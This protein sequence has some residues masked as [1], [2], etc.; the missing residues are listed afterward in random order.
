MRMPLTRESTAK[1]AAITNAIEKATIIIADVEAVLS[2]STTSH[3]L[4]NG[5][6]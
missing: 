5:G 3:G 6:D 1:M 4:T 2:V